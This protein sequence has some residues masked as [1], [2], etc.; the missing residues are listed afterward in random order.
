MKSQKVYVA[1]GMTQA[2]SSVERTLFYKNIARVCQQFGYEVCIPYLTREE[3]TAPSGY[4]SPSEIYE[5]DL[6]QLATSDLVIAYIGV[7]AIGVGIELGLA[8]CY[9]IPVITLAEWQTEISPMVLGHPRHFV[10]IEFETE[11][12]CS[13]A[14]AAALSALRRVPYYEPIP[15]SNR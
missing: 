15:A 4:F 7:P 9:R 2:T 13:E 1:G 6:N 14:L 10:H 12:E 11:E 3:S 5:W 8:A